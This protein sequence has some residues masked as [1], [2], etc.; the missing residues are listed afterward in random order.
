MCAPVV[1][2]AVMGRRVKFNSLGV[3]GS[4]SGLSQQGLQLPETMISA[5]ALMGQLWGKPHFFK[6]AAAP[7]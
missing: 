6:K 4:D 2:D 1:A 3:E 5:Q 7:T